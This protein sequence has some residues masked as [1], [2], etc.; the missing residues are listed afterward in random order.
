VSR[1]QEK[2]NWRADHFRCTSTLS[3]AQVKS[4]EG[5]LLEGE[6]CN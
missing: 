6:H 4:T 2:V 3:S 1:G 5:G